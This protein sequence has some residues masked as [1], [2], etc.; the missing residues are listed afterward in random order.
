VGQAYCSAS[1]AQNK[2]KVI[3]TQSGSVE[4]HTRISLTKLRHKKTPEV[5]CPSG[6]LVFI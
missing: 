1:F 3:A 5:I 6:V 4:A 2:N